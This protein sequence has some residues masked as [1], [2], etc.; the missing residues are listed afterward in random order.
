MRLVSSTT[1]V[2]SPSN[3]LTYSMVENCYSLATQNR[4]PKLFLIQCKKSLSFNNFFWIYIYNS[5]LTFFLQYI[6]ILNQ[7]GTKLEQMQWFQKVIL[8]QV[9]ERNNS[10]RKFDVDKPMGMLMT[11]DSKIKVS[12]NK[13][14]VDFLQ[15]PISCPSNLEIRKNGASNILISLCS[16]NLVLDW[17]FQKKN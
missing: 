17:V 16:P 9:P 10:K 1:I 12:S 7:F 5:Y 6:L 3:L 8:C 14:R 13:N 2:F 4:Y 15:I 11:P